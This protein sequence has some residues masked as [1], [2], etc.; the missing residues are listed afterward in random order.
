MDTLLI[1]VISI[2]WQQVFAE[3]KNTIRLVSNNL[4]AWVKTASGT[5]KDVDQIYIKT[6]SAKQCIRSR[7]CST[8]ISLHCECTKSFIRN[9]QQ[10]YPYIANAQN[11][12]IR[13]Q[14]E[15]NIRDA[16]NPFIRNNQT[17]FTY[18]HRSP[19]IYQDARSYQVPFTYN[20]RSPS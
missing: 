3:S 12:V 15:P 20:H 8:T 5:W 11:P 16:Q 7:E 14:Y 4:S 6:P 19:S 17:P 9:A 10:P 13:D 2:I 18:Q 1:R